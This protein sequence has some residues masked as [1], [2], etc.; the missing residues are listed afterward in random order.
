M[1][2]GVKIGFSPFADRSRIHLTDSQ[3]RSWEQ[4]GFLV[5]ER[6]ISPETIDA[7]NHLISG[8][9]HDRGTVGSYRQVTVDVLHGEHIGKRMLLADV[10]P[11]AFDGP[12]KINDLYL[13]S[14]VVRSCNLDTGLVAMIGELLNGDPVI[15][16]SLNFIYGSQQPPHFD[17]WFMPP[18]VENHMAVSSICLE[19]VHP[20][21][22]PV[23]YYPGSHRFPAYRFSHGG[24]HAIPE[25]M[26]DCEAHVERLIAE[27]GLKPQHFLGKKGDVLL[28]HAQLL[29]GGSPIADPQRSRKSLVT[30][31]WRAQD[32]PA[33]QVVRF[34]T[35]GNYLRRSHQPVTQA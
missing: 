17:T 33:E 27:A 9:V 19:D 2:S 18:L 30:H 29:H 23:V 10:P 7:V 20:D 16:N 22:G 13:D 3:R 11:A 25:E 26:S 31:Y 15:C 6:F 12:V 8:F 14:D 34:T 5:L 35:G 21:A 28:W 4:D 32:L 1:N 24:L